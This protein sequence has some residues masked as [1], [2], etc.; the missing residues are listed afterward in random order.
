M[1]IPTITPWGLWVYVVFGLSERVI[2]RVNVF[3]SIPSVNDTDR[4]GEWQPVELSIPSVNDTDRNGEWQPVELSIPSVNDT[5]RNGEWQP[6]ENAAQT[7]SKSFLMKMD[8]LNKI[9]QY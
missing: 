6:V 2:Q 4:N 8:R 9:S 7:D 5:D 3:L 1:Q